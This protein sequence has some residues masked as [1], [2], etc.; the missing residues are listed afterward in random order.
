[1][2][3]WARIVVGLSL[4]IALIGAEAG[5]AD[6]PLTVVVSPAAATNT[7]GTEH[8]L[9][10]T[11]TDGGAPR[12]DVQLIF[13]VNPDRPGATP[14]FQQVHVTDA[15]GRATLCYT[16]TRAG[17]DAIDVIVDVDRNGISDPFVDEFGASATKFWLGFERVTI[18]PED[19]EGAVGAER[20][21]TA[22]AEGRDA[23]GALVPVPGLQMIF[24][25]GGVTSGFQEV[26]MTD[27]GG[28]ATLCYAGPNRGEDR[29][30]VIVD[31]D[32]N[33][34]SDP[35]VDEAGADTTMFWLGPDR[36]TIA[37][38]D[39][40]NLVGTEHCVTARVE[41]RNR[42]GAF[43]PVA[44]FRLIFQVARSF[45]VL[46]EGTG[47]TDVHGESP[48]CY[49]S[50]LFG[51]EQIFVIV[52][53]NRNG[54]SDGNPP[55]EFGGTAVKF[56]TR[57]EAV[58]V[59]PALAT[60]LVG[61]EHCMFATTTGQSLHGQIPLGGIP[62]VFRVSGAT[63]AFEA[64]RTTDPLGTATFCY[65]GTNG[66][67]DSIVVLVDRDLDGAADSP[68]LPVTVHKTWRT[69]DGDGDG[70]ADPDDNCPL[71]ANPDQRDTDRDGRGDACD[72]DDDND[73]IT[74]EAE[75]AG[76]TD[77]DGVPNSLDGDDDG[78]GI[79]TSLEL[80]DGG[81]H[82]G[83]V[84]GDG[85]PNYLDADSDGDGVSDAIEGRGDADG[86]GVPNY[87]DR[88]DD[89]DGIA[90]ADEG[91]GDA[92]GDG[93]PNYLDRDSDGD[94]IPDATEG[95][96]DADGDG[97]PNYLDRDSDG[98][99]IPDATEG[100][101]DSDGDGAPDYLD[102]DD[103]GDGVPT[104]R[105]NCARTP[106]PGQEDADRD[107]IG[108]ACDTSYLAGRMTGGGSVFTADRTRVTH[109]FT[110]R[111]DPAA[112]PNSLE[113]NW[114]RNAFHLTRQT[115]AFCGDN[116]AIDPGRPSPGFDTYAGAGVGRLN[117]IDGATATWVFTDGGEPG[118]GDTARLVIRD[119]A[120]RVVL[121]V[122]DPLDRGNQQAH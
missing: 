12:A 52:D 77:G 80:A 21:F 61:E 71:V 64:S 87:L 112:G 55:D 84:D 54:V 18:A 115:S 5:H 88:D 76:D 119:P 4:L 45:V 17:T 81:P 122:S 2:S 62:I 108:D 13:L 14:A 72:P 6:A 28:R 90:T 114:A 31:L 97:V 33:G 24:V 86:D 106:N 95:S 57:P 35:H 98:D 1:M 26:R 25:I 104:A 38:A 53:L 69:P 23:A 10:A 46:S 42:V 44:D 82:G 79:A 73:G 9:T 65:T 66:G 40:T 27:A 120:G 74:D 47:T 39:A 68:T 56:W 70:V 29:I 92:D 60:N 118:T 41:G 116:P 78:D 110:L 105:D 30:D 67:E 102:A 34:V 7:I 121:S 58:T 83:D 3:G 101:G 50:A 11:A 85:V 89:G 113:V 96:G 37:P 117:G 75:G 94:G 36:V 99:G 100:R 111:C 48:F 91:T 16:G 107:G 103:D 109:G 43:V 32:R 93:V 15:T 19:G 59:V 51:E 63:P 8:C 20:C 22:R 49:T